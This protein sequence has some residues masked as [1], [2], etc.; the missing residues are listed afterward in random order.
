MVL[1]CFVHLMTNLY[2]SEYPE[3]EVVSVWH[4]T[5]QHPWTLKFGGQDFHWQQVRPRWE[6]LFICQ[7]MTV[8]ITSCPFLSSPISPFLVSSSLSVSVP[9]SYLCPGFL[10]MVHGSCLRWFPCGAMK[11]DREGREKN[12]I[13]KGI[14]C[15]QLP[16][17]PQ[18]RSDAEE[19]QMA[20][21]T[22]Q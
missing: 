19:I 14:I 3:K 10:F 2:I 8:T 15:C 7:C 12:L 1:S 16:A 9:V 20:R 5:Y 18:S 13:K 4:P 11:Q 21:K 6:V 17:R 22:S